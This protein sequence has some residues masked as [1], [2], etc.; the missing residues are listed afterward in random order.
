VPV[1]SR[2]VTATGNAPPGRP[3]PCKIDVLVAHRRDVVKD[4]RI[5]FAPLGPPA[6]QSPLHLVG[7]SG[8]HHIRNQG[9][10]A[11]LCDEF[12]GALTST[13]TDAGATDLPLQ[14]VSALIVV[15]RA[16]Q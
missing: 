8:H 5:D 14:R 10:R 9:Q 6:A 4:L 11:G 2:A 15:D 3:N 1:G 16:E 13:R 7:I 12:F